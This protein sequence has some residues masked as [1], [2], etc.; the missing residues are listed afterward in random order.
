MKEYPAKAI[1]QAGLT[2]LLRVRGISMA[3]STNWDFLHGIGRHQV[4]M[5]PAPGTAPWDTFMTEFTATLATEDTGFL[6]AA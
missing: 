6:C 1:I 5:N 3:G 4:I 2:P